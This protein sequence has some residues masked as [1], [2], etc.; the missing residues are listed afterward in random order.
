MSNVTGKLTL[1]FQRNKLNLY[2]M[3]A[4]RMLNGHIKS[5]DEL[6]PSIQQDVSLYIGFRFEE[7]DNLNSQ[8]KKLIE[9]LMEYWK[10]V[11]ETDTKRRKYKDMIKKAKDF[12]K[13]VDDD[14]GV[15]VEIDFRVI[16]PEKWKKAADIIS[17]MME[18]M[19][20]CLKTGGATQR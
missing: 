16:P 9:C 17:R 20:D 3:T 1:D 15:V 10:F 18:A 5:V 11:P 12:L 19:K 6:P 14:V 2:W 4:K 8:E 7:P 13:G